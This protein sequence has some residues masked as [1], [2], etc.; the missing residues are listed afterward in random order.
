MP[1]GLAT[2]AELESGS[3]GVDSHE[4]SRPSSSLRNLIVS[5]VFGNLL[6]WYDFGVFASFSEEISEAFFTGGRLEELLKVYG[7]FAVAFFAR[8]LGGFLLGLIGDR[9]GRTLSLQISVVAMGAS[10]LVISVLPTNSI[11]PYAIGP[12][13]T[14]LLVLARIVQ[15]LSVGGELIGSIIY[16]VENDEEAKRWK[17]LVSCI[18]FACSSSGIGIAYLVS[19]IITATVSEEARVVWGWRLAFALGV[20]AGAVGFMFRSCLS[21]SHSFTTAIER[22]MVRNKNQHPFA[23]ALKQKPSA[24]LMLMTLM[25]LLC[26]F[27]GAF[28]WYNLAWLEVF[29]TELVEDGLSEL[30]GRLLNTLLI[31]MGLAGGLLAMAVIVDRGPKMPLHRYI[32]VSTGLLIVLTPVF[33]WLMSF[34]RRCYLCVAA[35]QLAGM[36]CLAPAVAPLTLYLTSQMPAQLQYT[37]IGLSYNIGLAL[38]GGTLPYV[39]TAID[40]RSSWVIAPGFYLSALALLGFA[41]VGLGELP[42]V[43][44][45]RE[46]LAR[47]M[48]A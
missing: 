21:E 29:Y 25:T 33:L 8:P 2:S 20:P 15:G 48:N 16:M 1:Q 38:F 46:D 9:Y 23:F 42:V 40:V 35:G 41:S 22:F 31:F 6:E 10:A 27:F 4:T 37:G 30:Q 39:A 5:S 3:D 32:L 19:T 36:L 34:G 28:G 47:R 24:F 17:C 12:A 14:V 13:A 26:G 44:G 18:P 11:A 43:R 45:M 7:V